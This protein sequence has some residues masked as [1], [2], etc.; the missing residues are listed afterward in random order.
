MQNMKHFILI[1]NMG[2]WKWN[3][4][5]SEYYNKIYVKIFNSLEEAKKAKEDSFYDDTLIVEGEIIE[6]DKNLF[7]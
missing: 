6:G 3:G 7:G 1:A 2:D 4:E 5:E